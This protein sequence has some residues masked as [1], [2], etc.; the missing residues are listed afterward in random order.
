MAQVTETICFFISAIALIRVISLLHAQCVDETRSCLFALRGE[1]FLYASDN[2]LLETR[3]YRQL[4][5]LMN[6]FIRYA[7]RL[8]AS[9][10]LL[11]SVASRMATAPS[12]SFVSTWTGYL[13]ELDEVNREKMQSFY[14]RHELILA[15]HIVHR[16][17]V[18]RGLVRVYAGYHDL[19]RP[20][21]SH[22][23]AEEVILNAVVDRVPWKT[24][25]AEAGAA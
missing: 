19:R 5:D 4:R 13:N 1:M 20:T 17:L 6:G 15:T 9:R 24:M 16:S 11:F 25:E 2:D 21:R 18:L 23:A 7:H 3:A 10:V 22:G 14:R 8:T 12:P